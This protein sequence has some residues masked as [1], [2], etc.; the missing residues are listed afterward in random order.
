MRRVFTVLTAAGIPILLAILLIW[1]LTLQLKPK[2]E[3]AACKGALAQITYDD[4][5]TID[6]ILAPSLAQS[7][8]L[9]YSGL[10][11]SRSQDGYFA[12]SA[13]DMKANTSANIYVISNDGQHL[14]KITNYDEPY[15]A[16]NPAWSAD[17]QSLVFAL[18]WVSEQTYKQLQSDLATR[19]LIPQTDSTLTPLPIN[20]NFDLFKMNNQGQIL[21]NLTQSPALDELQP[22]WSPDGKHIVFIGSTVYTNKLFIMN[23]DGSHQQRLIDLEASTPKWSPD[24]RYIVF[25]SD[26]ISMISP[27]GSGLRKLVEPDGDYSNLSAPQWSKDSQYIVF[28]AK[29]KFTYPQNQ[30]FTELHV[31]DLLGQ[32]RCYLKSVID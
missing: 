30:S 4:I 3:L 28:R 16:I 26:G 1:H 18:F 22:D 20:G 32:Q 27:D 17:G 5:Y 14:R 8:D 25:S 21:Q 10:W 24:S 29:G 2:P 19:T 15:Y 7:M 23:N 6:S 11:A 31:V 12:F 13:R 9:R